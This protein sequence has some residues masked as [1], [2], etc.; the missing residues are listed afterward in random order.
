MFI[1]YATPHV[2]QCTSKADIRTGQAV[3]LHATA[4]LVLPSQCLPPF[5]S[6][7]TFCKCVL[8]SDQNMLCHHYN[9]QG[10]CISIEWTIWT[11]TLYLCW[12]HNQVHAA[13][14]YFYRTDLKRQAYYALLSNNDIKY[15]LILKV[16][17]HLWFTHKPGQLPT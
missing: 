17:M 14:P 3:E 2:G 4:S 13:I 6:F 10:S 11:R 1:L 8:F 7:G 15:I 16:Y 9:E 5:V 12:F